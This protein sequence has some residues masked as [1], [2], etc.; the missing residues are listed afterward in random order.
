MSLTQ[1]EWAVLH[2]LPAPARKNRSVVEQIIAHLRGFG[3]KGRGPQSGGRGIKRSVLPDV[4]VEDGT[5]DDWYSFAVKDPGD[6]VVNTDSVDL[7]GEDTGEGTD[8]N[9]AELVTSEFDKGDVDSV[10][11]DFALEQ[12]GDT[13]TN[14]SDYKFVIYETDPDSPIATYGDDSV[15]NDL[16]RA[17]RTVDLSGI[18]G[19]GKLRFRSW[20][21][22]SGKYE[23]FGGTVTAWDIFWN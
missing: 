6:Y 21:T 9:Y 3:I 10:D 19:T 1:H 20:R 22:S 16:S 15:N 4:L 14:P 23:T 18:D 17:V 2:D 7:I 13:N 12:S 11:I 8:G 5:V